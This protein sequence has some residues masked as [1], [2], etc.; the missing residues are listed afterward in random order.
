MIF[1][2]PISC[3][4]RGEQ[5][6]ANRCM[7]HPVEAKFAEGHFPVTG[8]QV[9]LSTVMEPAPSCDASGVICDPSY[10]TS[11]IALPT[12]RLSPTAVLDPSRLLFHAARRDRAWLDRAWRGKSRLGKTSRG[13]IGR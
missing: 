8:K 4:N 6:S 1:D 7:I 10:D 5:P 2:F 3:E 13:S 11:R 12:R 9:D